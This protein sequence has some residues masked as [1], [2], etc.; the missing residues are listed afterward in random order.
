VEGG[1]NRRKKGD[2]HSG[3]Q[4]KNKGKIFL[5][6]QSRKNAAGSFSENWSWMFM[7]LKFQTHKHPE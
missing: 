5:R 1:G 6:R 4:A 2:T 7:A 3:P